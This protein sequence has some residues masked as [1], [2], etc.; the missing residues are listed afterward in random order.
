MN[1]AIGPL[2]VPMVSLKHGGLAIR[3]LLDQQAAMLARLVP[4][5]DSQDHQYISAFRCAGCGLAQRANTPGKT[6]TAIASRW[7]T[8]LRLRGPPLKLRAPA[9][10]RG[11]TL[12][13][14]GFENQKSDQG[15]R[16]A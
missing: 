1:A 12:R 3:L 13:A 5:N 16:L 10:Q 6:M 8:G 7:V 4:E 14:S 2:L 15:A 11:I 9:M